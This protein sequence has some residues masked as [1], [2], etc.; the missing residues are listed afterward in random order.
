MSHEE[1][2]KGGNHRVDMAEHDAQVKQG[3]R[4]HVE[5]LKVYDVERCETLVKEAEG[6]YAKVMKS[7]SRHRKARLQKECKTSQTRA[8]S[9]EWSSP[10][11][12]ACTIQVSF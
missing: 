2:T 5:K 8:S 12:V 3:R 11:R 4:S 10:H 7:K 1:G 6:Y 9:A